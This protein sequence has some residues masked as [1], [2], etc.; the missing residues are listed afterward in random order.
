MSGEPWVSALAHDHALA[1][2]RANGSGDVDIGRQHRRLGLLD[3]EEQRIVVVD[4]LQQ[5]DPAARADAAHA[6]HLARRVDDAIARQQRA[7]V[8]RQRIDI[9]RS[10]LFERHR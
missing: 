7:A 3:L 1:L 9:G 6:H 10:M 8:E 5:D 2:V 4:A